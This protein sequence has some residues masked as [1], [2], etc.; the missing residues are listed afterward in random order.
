MTNLKMSKKQLSLYEIIAQAILFLVVFLI[1]TYKAIG[2]GST[3][4]SIDYVKLSEAINRFVERPTPLDKLLPYS[5]IIMIFTI[6]LLLSYYYFVKKTYI[7]HRIISIMVIV[8]MVL[9]ITAIIAR[10][11]E[12][13]SWRTN[14]ELRSRTFGLS[15]GFFFIMMNMLSIIVIETYKKK[16][17]LPIEIKKDENINNITQKAKV[18]NQSE[19]VKQDN[20]EELLKYKKLLDAEAITEEEYNAKKRELLNL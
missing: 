2:T 15:V 1:P 19:L 20:T 4:Y 8:E 13:Q 14:G 3:W 16:S 6:A 18:V 17:D 12:K 5:T 7:N 11:L 10:M 9:Y